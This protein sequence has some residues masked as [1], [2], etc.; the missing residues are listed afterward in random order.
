MKNKLLI[1]IITIII[2][3]IAFGIILYSLL[4]NNNK[5]VENNEVETELAVAIQSEENL[6]NYIVDNYDFKATAALYNV[7][8]N[9][10][11]NQKEGKELEEAFL[12]E[13]NS[14]SDDQIEE[15]KTDAKEKLKEI[16]SD[17]NYK[18][19][20]KKELDSADFRYPSCLKIIESTYKTDDG[21]TMTICFATYNEKI[22]EIIS[23]YTLDV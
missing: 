2:F 8:A 6:E 5:N 14:V 11:E 18:F 20:E 17:K 16:L 3:V 19:V 15:S 13:Y 9:Q 1:I 23:V 4:I 12:N 7:L 21:S 22:V 10:D